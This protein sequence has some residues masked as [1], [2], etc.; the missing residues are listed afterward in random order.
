[1]RANEAVYAARGL[2]HIKGLD[3]FDSVMSSLRIISLFYGCCQTKGFDWVEREF[4]NWIISVAGRESRLPKCSASCKYRMPYEQLKPQKNALRIEMFY[5]SDRC[6]YNLK[7]GRI[8]G[9]PDDY[10]PCSFRSN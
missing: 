6:G 4:V 1:M 9:R 2:A 5:P 8:G 3:L 7:P 10:Y